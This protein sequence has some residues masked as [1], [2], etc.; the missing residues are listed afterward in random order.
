M[1]VHFIPPKNRVFQEVFS[2][3]LNLNKQRFIFPDV[4]YFSLRLQK[5]HFKNEFTQPRPLEG[6]HTSVRTK[7]KQKCSHA[8]E[9]CVTDSEDEEEGNPRNRHHI[10]AE[11]QQNEAP[12]PSSG[13]VHRHCNFQDAHHTKRNNDGKPKWSDGYLQTST[14]ADG[15]YSSA[16]LYGLAD[17]S[18]RSAHVTSNHVSSGRPVTAPEQSPRP[19][20]PII[21]N[22]PSQL[23]EKT[24][25]GSTNNNLY[26]KWFRPVAK[27]DEVRPSTALLKLQESW[28]KTEAHRKFHRQ[29]SEDAPDIRRKP[30]LRITTNERRHVIPETGIH[31][32]YLHR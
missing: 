30:D 20:S 6:R 13:F 27:Y 17:R 7:T 10:E 12:F 28:S 2:L 31:V 9:P 16:E 24:M 14:L 8:T 25:T 26:P 23:P 3:M 1:V 18:F 4:I 29:F 22:M 19:R 11:T 15:S 5:E 32:F 21:H